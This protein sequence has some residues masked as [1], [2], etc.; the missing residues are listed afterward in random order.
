[1]PWY[2]RGRSTGYEEIDRWAGGVGWV[3]H[4]EEAGRRASHAV[5]T[6]DG[7][8]LFDPLEAPGITALIDGLGDVAGVA[9][10]SDYH[11]RDADVFA[12][13]YDVPVHVPAWFRRV[14]GRIEAPVEA[15][16]DSL[17]GS[18]IAVRRYTPFPGW[19]EGIA[20]DTAGGTV[21]V[22]EALSALPSYRT[23]AE[24]IGV[25][26]AARL[27]PPRGA[28]AGFDAEQLLFGHGSGIL[29]SPGQALEETL[30]GA[31]RRLPQALIDHG[32]TRLR[33]TLAGIRN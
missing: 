28:L 10:L 26:T 18:G 13:R 25:H 16:T 15:V 21:Y 22:P 8:W 27:R 14:P 3:A 4:P 9:V 19:R 5:R 17:G 12:R 33:A 23:P 7:V 29:D 32:L 24:G 31:R 30:A 20:V 11:T 1:M 6:A 2:E